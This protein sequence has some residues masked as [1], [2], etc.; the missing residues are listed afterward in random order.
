MRVDFVRDDLVG[1]RPIM[2]SIM[3][4]HVWDDDNHMHTEY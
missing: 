2:S 3:N 1:G 4:V